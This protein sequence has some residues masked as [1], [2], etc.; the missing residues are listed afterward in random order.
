MEPI[1]WFRP[2]TRIYSIM[3]FSKPQFTP[4]R[5]NGCEYRVD[6]DGTPNP[7]YVDLLDEDPGIAGQKFVCVSFVSPEDIIKRK[8]EYIFQQFLNTWDMNKSIEKFSQFLNFISA[9]H[10]FD[11]EELQ[12]D[13][14]E[15]IKDEGDNIKSESSVADDFKS[16]REKFGDTLGE[17]FD[18]KNEFSTTT[19]GV[20]IRGVFPNQEEAEMKCKQLRELDSSHDVYVGPV[21]LWMPF[22]PDAY[23]TGRVEYLEDELNQLMSEKKKNEEK[24]KLEFDK[25]VR[26]TKESAIKDNIE[27]ATDSGNLL[28]QTIDDKGNLVNHN[29]IMDATDEER[30]PAPD[31]TRDKK[32]ASADIISDMMGGDG[33]KSGNYSI[34]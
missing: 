23:K 10:D 11:A 33:S 26:D 9:K 29:S 6:A 20:K 14:A 27:K 3:S 12:G 31:T 7:R 4:G 16:Y 32:T 30:T 8:E 19:R 1:K 15:F 24:A 2:N 28:T 17:Q 21:G 25:R 22:H 13:L 18:K 5:T 34:D